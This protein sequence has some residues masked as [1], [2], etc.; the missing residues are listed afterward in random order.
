MFPIF[1]IY[2]KSSTE[3][4]KHFDCLVQIIAA[5]QLNIK[6]IITYFK[7]F[8]Q[9]E[10]YPVVCKVVVVRLKL[11]PLTLFQV[12]VL[13]KLSSQLIFEFFCDSLP[14]IQ[15]VLTNTVNKSFFLYRIFLL[16]NSYKNAKLANLNYRKLLIWK[17]TQ[18]E[19]KA[20]SRPRRPL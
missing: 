12:L 5:L 15:S 9:S 2:T 16:K 7:Q 20:I 6:S 13:I 11:A 10:Y 18:K 19:L 4:Y 3:L 14:L 17:D 1:P 8:K